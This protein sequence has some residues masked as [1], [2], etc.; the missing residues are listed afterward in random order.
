MKRKRTFI[1]DVYMG[2][3]MEGE[4]EEPLLLSILN[5]WNNN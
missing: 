4:R 1:V 5:K 2:E 3:G